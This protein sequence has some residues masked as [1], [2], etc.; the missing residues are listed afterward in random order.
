M[1]HRF[2]EEAVL[3]DGRRV[4][5]RPMGERDGDALYD[6]FQRMPAAYRRFAWDAVE[7]RAIID[8]WS[9]NIDYAKVFPLLAM[10]GQQDR[11]RRDAASPP[12]RT[13]PDGRPHQLDDRS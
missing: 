10:A 13:A 6:F 12:R 1:P 11:R 4:L 9:R 7:N 3:R 8:E 2:P 5:L